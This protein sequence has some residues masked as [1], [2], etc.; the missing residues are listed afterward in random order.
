[1]EQ[2]DCMGVMSTYKDLPKPTKKLLNLGIILALLVALPLFVWSVV[3][4]TFDLREKAQQQIAIDLTNEPFLGYEDS[5]VTIVMYSDFQCEFCKSFINNTLSTILSTYS[6]QVK[7][8]HKDF[9]ITTSHPLAQTAALAG[10]CAYGQNKFWEMHSLIFENQETLEETSFSQFATILSLDLPLFNSCMQDQTTLDEISADFNE[11]TTLGVI[12]TPTFFV[13]DQKISGLQPFEN[14]KSIID[15]ELTDD[16]YFKDNG[17]SVSILTTD[18]NPNISID[19]DEII[20]GE[21][22]EITVNYSLQNNLKYQHATNSA[23]PVVLLVNDVFKSSSSVPYSSIA[24]HQDGYTESQTTSF[25]ATGSATNIKVI[26]DPNNILPETNEDNNTLEFNFG[27][28]QTATPTATPTNIATPTATSTTTPSPEEPNSCGGTC[29]SNYNCK[30]NLYCYQGYCRNPI[31]SE[32]TDCNCASATATPTA[33]SNATTKGSGDTSVTSKTATPKSTAKPSP[34]STPNYTEGMTL[35]EKTKGFSREEE[36]LQTTEPENMFINKYA[37]YI[38]AGFG[39][40]VLS[41]VIYALK[42]KRDNNIP[43]IVPPTNI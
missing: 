34:K 28:S 40:I 33:T 38:V 30:S 6:N 42:K 14:F 22:Y 24:I 23:I 13:N 16:I 21:T 20:N 4:M 29:G 27:Q 2:Y 10:Q 25:T 15:Q 37:I 26:Y 3:N 9:P 19:P 39:L 31:C 32:K 11:G 8:V 18:R 1:M 41:V 17:N 43:H 5:P 35:I 12:G 7:F 36:V